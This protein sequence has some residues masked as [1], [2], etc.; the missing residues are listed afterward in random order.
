MKHCNS[1]IIYTNWTYYCLKILSDY[2]AWRLLNMFR[3]LEIEFLTFSFAT[4]VINR[5]KLGRISVSRNM[6][7]G[8]L[9]VGNV[10]SLSKGNCKIFQDCGIQTYKLF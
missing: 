3:L 10:K 9:K 2:L 4:A 5:R 8:I 7:F 6:K 1:K